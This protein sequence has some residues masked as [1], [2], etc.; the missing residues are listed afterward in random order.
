[1]HISAQAPIT[2]SMAKRPLRGIGE[3]SAHAVQKVAQADHRPQITDHAVLEGREFPHVAMHRIPLVDQK[4]VQKILKERLPS[5]VVVRSGAGMGSGYAVDLNAYLPGNLRVPPNRTIILTNRHVVARTT[6][7]RGGKTT[8]S[9]PRTVEIELMS[10]Q[11]YQGKVI[12]VDPG[13]DSAFV[14]VDMPR[15]LRPIPIGNWRT[16]Q[17]GAQ[18][19][20]LGH[21]VGLTWSVTH[22]IVSH[23]AR[24]FPGVPHPVIQTDAP[25]NPGNSGGPMIMLDETGAVIGTNTFKLVR[26]GVENLGFAFHA[27]TQMQALIQILLKGRAVSRSDGRR[28]AA[29]HIEPHQHL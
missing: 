19:L 18:V 21:P 9:I 5:V 25:I 11:K 10:G 20:I 28:D 29:P 1:M 24:K 8:E 4:R 13:S 27:E 7:L 6:T 14:M 2:Q 17:R 22:G 23:P 12:A 26:E 16:L 3:F 15:P